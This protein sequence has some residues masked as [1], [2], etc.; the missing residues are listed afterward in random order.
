MDTIT[1]AIPLGDYRIEILTSSG[2]A[3]IFDVQTSRPQRVPHG[4]AQVE[5]RSKPAMG[6]V[7]GRLPALEGASS[8]RSAG[9]NDRRSTYAIS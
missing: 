8:R 1:K 7:S 4:E 5:R 2:I 3:G 9:R 6:C